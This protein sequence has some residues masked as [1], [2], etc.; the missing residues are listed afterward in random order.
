MSHGLRKLIIVGVGI[1]LL[2]ASGG[3]YWFVQEQGEIIHDAYCIDRASAMVIQFM[4]DNDGNYPRSW[5][6]L[7]PSLEKL[8][9]HDNS[10]SFEEIQLRV[11]IDFA[12]HPRDK[13]GDDTRR[14]VWLKSGRHV[15]WGKPD[16]SERIQAR[17]TGR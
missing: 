13:V 11:E 14:F 6:D 2:L 8:R 5:N 9:G 1:T 15:S 3:V 17:I 10:F 7:R 4:D 12:A 16:P